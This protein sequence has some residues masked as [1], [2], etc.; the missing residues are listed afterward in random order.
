MCLWIVEEN[1]STPRK[2]T[3]LGMNPE[4]KPR[5]VLLEGD[6]ANQIIW[7]LI[8]VKI[9]L[10]NRLSFILIAMLE[11]Y[12]QSVSHFFFVIVSVC[13]AQ[14][15][16]CKEHAEL[17]IFLCCFSVKCPFKGICHKTAHWSGRILLVSMETA[18]TKK[19]KVTQHEQGNTLQQ[20]RHL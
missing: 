1:L 17:D 7:L 16:L 10:N 12:F 18:P 14:T 19:K 9:N 5:T 3:H 13:L 15:F 6:S 20:A 11:S 2:P 8:K 4:I